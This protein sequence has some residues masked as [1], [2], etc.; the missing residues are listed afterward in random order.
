MLQ[1]VP[2]VSTQ[3]LRTCSPTSLSSP[4][5]QTVHVPRATVGIWSPV[6]GRA[7]VFA[8][9]A[10]IFTPFFFPRLQ[11]GVGGYNCHNW[12]RVVGVGGKGA[13]SLSLS[14]THTSWH[15][16]KH[17]C[18]HALTHT[19]ATKR[20][21]DIAFLE[22]TLTVVTSLHSLPAPI[23]TSTVNSVSKLNSL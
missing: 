2:N 23:K 14:H 6:P 8:T 17:T 5:S 1:F 10:V 13:L 4:T 11:G 15:T 9:A 19:H 22:C 18:T 16:H 7:T 21:R 20:E 12:R 3:H